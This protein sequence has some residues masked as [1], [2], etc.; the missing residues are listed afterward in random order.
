ML[1]AGAG[2]LPEAGDVVEYPLS[3]VVLAQLEERHRTAGIALLVGRNRDRG[4]ARAPPSLDA[5]L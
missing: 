1:S 3:D 5:G 4:D 2:R